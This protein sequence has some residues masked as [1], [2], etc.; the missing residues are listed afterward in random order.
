M[1]T[2]LVLSISNLENKLDNTQRGVQ[3]TDNSLQQMLP[4]IRS[5]LSRLESNLANHV[6]GNVGELTG[7]IVGRGGFWTGIWLLVVFQA[8]AFVVYEY[9]RS[10]KDDM[11]KYV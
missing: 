2:A 4:L 7:S 8:A 3:S 10:K 5:E 9:Y 11:K 1:L 6:S